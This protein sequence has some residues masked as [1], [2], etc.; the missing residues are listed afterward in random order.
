[1]SNQLFG[2][3]F[4]AT[5]GKK[6]HVAEIKKPGGQED[7]TIQIIQFDI[8]AI[9]EEL[10]LRQYR[11]GIAV[12]I[13][14]S[15]PMC[16]KSIDFGEQTK[17]IF[18]LSEIMGVTRERPILPQVKWKTLKVSQLDHPPNLVLAKLSCEAPYI[19]A[20][21][22]ELA[23]LKSLKSEFLLTKIQGELELET[24]A[25]S[26]ADDYPVAIKQGET[27]VYTTIGEMKKLSDRL[28]EGSTLE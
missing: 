14:A 22:L 20:H 8:N 4:S 11:A 18:T 13:F 26:E 25:D 23:R 21:F 7:E 3:K 12:H 27:E 10:Q 16:F 24:P 28:E 19:E 2:G 6:I 1:M 5:I 9:L 15:T 17:S